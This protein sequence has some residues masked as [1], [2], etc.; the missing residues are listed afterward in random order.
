[1]V[2]NHRAS[3]LFCALS[4]LILS[5]TAQAYDYTD[6]SKCR[7][8]YAKLY[9]QASL[10]QKDAYCKPKMA[11]IAFCTQQAVSLEMFLSQ[12]TYDAATTA[13][14]TTKYQNACVASGGATVAV[15]VAGSTAAPAT[16]SYTPPA[17][18]YGVAPLP[19]LNKS[20]EANIAD[21]HGDTLCIG[22]VNTEYQAAQAIYNRDVNMA[23]VKAEAAAAAAQAN[24]PQDQPAA[25]GSQNAIGGMLQGAGALMGYAEPQPQPQAA[26]TPSGGTSDSATLAPMNYT[27]PPAA[28]ES[29]V[30]AGNQSGG[31]ASDAAAKLDKSVVAKPAADVATTA[32]NTNLQTDKAAPTPDITL[33]SETLTGD[34]KAQMEQMSTT[35]SANFTKITYTDTAKAISRE[36]VDALLKKYEEVKTKC[37]ESSERTT[38]LCVEGT[39]PGAK[40]VRL[41]MDAA[42]PMM[43]AMNAQKACSSSSKV[44]DL[45]GLGLTAAN[46]VCIASKMKCEDLCKQAK[47]V[48]KTEREKLLTAYE[49]GLESD[50]LRIEPCATSTTDP[51][52]AICKQ[53]LKA[54]TEYGPKVKQTAVTVLDKQSEPVPGTPANMLAKCESKIRNIIGMMTNIAA[55]A[56]AKRGSDDCE[57]KLSASGAAGNAL[58]AKQYCEDSANSGSQFCKCQ[59]NSTAA[60]CPGAIAAG[61]EGGAGTNPTDAAGASIRPSSGV[62]SF[63]GGGSNGGG[64]GSSDYGL[65]NN[66]GEAGE[67]NPFAPGASSANGAAGGAAGVGSMGGA[68][69]GQGS[70]AE[71]AAKKKAD[72]DDKKWSFGAIAAGVSSMF[73]GKGG[74]AN[75]NG[76]LKNANALEARI[77]RK[78]ASDKYGMEVT[79]ASGISNWDKVHMTV[80]RVENTLMRGP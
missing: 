40:T 13:E 45:A 65:G 77:E 26:A 80:I 57:K 30:V 7:V 19:I 8:D 27:P 56:M 24:Q 63:A 54:G 73:G 50:R 18:A 61:T 43:M 76:D 14:L 11:P 78:I 28:L 60:G 64:K 23:R 71:A 5:A 70:A 37:T 2:I 10:E 36:A 69:G 3:I 29:A 6:L 31:L 21:C 20:L 66:K 33:A 48:L 22:R 12:K 44:T 1:M 35:A 55:L 15:T 79:P 72:E 52:A 67:Y 38:K 32:N 17:T 49:K 74:A 68:G 51:K 46:G 58:T 4:V 41:L 75:G 34:F 39:S 59:G 16:V 53:Q 42:G 47:E 25:G 9:P 62:S